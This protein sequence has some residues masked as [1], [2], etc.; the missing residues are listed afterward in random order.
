MSSPKC[1]PLLS[2]FSWGPACGSAGIQAYAHKGD[3]GVNLAF[4]GG[5]CG[6]V[7]L[8]MC[9]VL[10]LQLWPFLLRVWLVPGA[11]WGW[12]CYRRFGSGFGDVP[13]PDVFGSDLFGVTGIRW[14]SA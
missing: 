11:V 1:W 3:V 5:S 13:F 4:L 14:E 8:L 10:P 2:S 6:F 12:H 9:F 7:V